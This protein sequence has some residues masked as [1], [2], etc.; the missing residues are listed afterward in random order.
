MKAKSSVLLFVPS[1]PYKTALAVLVLLL[2]LEN[3]Q[4]LLSTIYT[5]AGRG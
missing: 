5:V 4:C 1:L 3:T 2:L